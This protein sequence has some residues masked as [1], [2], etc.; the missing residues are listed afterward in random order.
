MRGSS[1]F[2]LA[3]SGQVNPIVPI[4]NAQFIPYHTG[5]R[6]LLYRIIGVLEASPRQLILV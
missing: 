1:Y 2:L 3:V 5:V 6:L 4:I